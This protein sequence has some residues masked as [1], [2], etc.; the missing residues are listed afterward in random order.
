MFWYIHASTRSVQPPQATRLLGFLLAMMLSASIAHA[1]PD[2]LTLNEALRLSSQNSSLIGAAHA[3]VQASR[4]IA[5][6]AGQLPDPTLKVGVDNIPAN[7][8]DQWSTTRDFMTMRRVGIEQQWISADKRAA[9]TERAHRAVE[10]EEG[11]YLTNMVKVREE[12]AKAWVN[13]LYAQRT[14]TLLSAIEKQTAASLAALQVAHRGAKAT[15]SDVMQSQLALSQTQD[16]LRE[17]EQ[18][19][20][21][22]K[23]ALTRWI[24]IPV[25]SVADQAPSLVSHVSNLSME[26][27]EKYHPQVLLAQRA[28]SLADAEMTVAIRERRPDWSFEAGFSQRSGFSNMVSVGVSIPLPFNRS[29]RQDRD[30]A[31]RAAMGTQARL[32]YDDA[33]REVQTEI[34]TLSSRLE[35][36]KE[37]LGYLNA[38]VLPVAHQQA[39]LA[40]AAYRAGTGSLS[41]V[42]TARKMLLEQQLQLNELEKEAAL[43]WATL[44]HHVLPIEQA[45]IGQAE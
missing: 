35:S 36:L 1:Q 7:G 25:K 11:V 2:A 39:E 24:T 19:L 20:K 4:E 5:A 9:R 40:T 42:F 13:V 45:S 14:S 18:E 23:L 12:T 37:R 27:L 3:S 34:H 31:E 6:K 30:V 17:S 26:D 41:A 32:Q 15:A 10:A 8:P 29:E 43:T 16:A 28:I 21:S 22:S 33:L 38:E 44:E